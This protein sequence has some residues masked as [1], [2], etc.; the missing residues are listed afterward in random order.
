MNPS[1]LVELFTEEL[2][3]KALNSLGEAFSQLL[4]QALRDEGHLNE[5]SVVT[6]F[7]SPRRLGCHI[8]NVASTSPEKNMQ[9]RLLPVKI[10]LDAQGQATAPLLKKL[11]SLGLEGTDVSTLKTISDGKQDVLVIERTMAG[12]HLPESLNKALEAATTKLPIPKVMSYQRP[13]GSTVHFVRPA[14]KLVALHGSTV[15]DA[16]TL[17]LTSGRTT[18]G[19]RFLSKGPIEIATADG[20]EAQLETEGK[21]I[22][23][24][25]KRRAAIEQQLAEQAQGDQVVQPA[26]LVDEVCALVEWPVVYEAGFEKEF[27]EVPQECLILTMQANQKYFAIT[28]SN[29]KMKNRFLL[30]SNLLTNTPHLITSG[31]ERVLRARLADAK[32]FFDQDRKKSLESRLPGLASVVYHNKLGTQKDRNERLVK[33]AEWLAPITGASVEQAKRAALLCKADL[34]TDMVGE[35]PELQGNMGEHYARHDGETAEVAQAIADHY[36]PR[37]AGDQLPRNPVGLAVALADKLETLLGIYSIGL[38]PTGD[39]DPFALRRH[40]LGVIRMVIEKGLQLNLHAMLNQGSSL[41]AAYPDFK[42]STE[43]IAGFMMDRLRSYLKDQG[44]SSAE[45]DSV[46]ST[47]PSEFA[48][49]PKRLAAV[50]A[51]SQLPEATALAAANKRISNIL[52]KV[53]GSPV[54]LVEARLV[55]DAEKTLFAEVNKVAPA[56]TQAFEQGDFQQALLT[57]APLK[58][59]VDAFFDHVMVNDPDEALKNNR[60]ALLSWLHGLMNRV[61][62][63]SQLAQ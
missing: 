12:K 42:P 46:L 21:V 55:L 22:P 39:K 33:L 13:D 26:D 7:A 16:Q 27:L 2:P 11:V 35:F 58:A 62:D 23:S 17:G 52:K 30:V 14:H 4:S 38:V 1:L 9:E 50:R 40:A 61:A 44:Y 53:E 18:L 20:Y 31:N 10:G 37:F 63:I 51:F 29:G 45:V 3:P 6:A 49:L 15:V 8:T 25:A 36:S 47:Q 24:F 5:H 28:D 34:L 32:F 41:F 43:A 56:S 54:E 60:I 59:S 48:D 57:L 19:H